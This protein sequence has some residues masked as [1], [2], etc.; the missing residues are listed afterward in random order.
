MR[1][2]KPPYRADH[3][4]S[5]L[6]PPPVKEARARRQHG[7]ISAAE[8]REVEDR[9][10]SRVV[11]KQAALGLHTATDG[12][13]RRGSWHRDFCLFLDGIEEISGQPG[14]PFKGVTAPAFNM[15][16]AGPLHFP[17]N[18]P[19]LDHFRFLKEHA[20]TATP[21]MTIPSPSVLAPP[22]LAEDGWYRDVATLHRDMGQVYRDAIRAFYE[23]GC[24]YLQIDEVRI[25]SWADPAYR[26]RA[27]LRTDDPEEQLRTFARLVNSAL[28]G[29]PADMTIS[30]HNCRGNFRSSWVA[31]GGYE[32]V[33]E[34]LFNLKGIDA[35][36]LEFDSERAGGFEPLRLLP[37]DK[38]AVLG[39]V[40]T[41]SGVLEAKDTIKRR[42]DEAGK[43]IDLDRVCLSPQCGFASTEEGNNLSEDEQW[44]KLAFVRDIA[45][46]VWG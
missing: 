9:E 27:N 37:K 40:T 1:R 32:P 3:V 42:L 15:K 10:I 44:A 22:R 7:D 31:E 25:V 34:L 2:S 5:L 12:E 29:R 8:L 35:Y 18:H 38:I 30:M 13:I 23:A 26:S 33:A 28:E 11:A 46:E 6:R 20:K 14:I 45:E 17:A 41:K 36:F 16:I 21:K 24:R 43:F 39:L 4:G 19:H